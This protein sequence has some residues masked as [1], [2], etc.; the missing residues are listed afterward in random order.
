[1]VLIGLFVPSNQI[2]LKVYRGDD[3]E[4]CF[5][6][7]ITPET[8]CQDVVACVSS[9][10]GSYLT[11]QWQ[12][13]EKALDPHENLHAILRGWDNFR[14]EVRFIVREPLPPAIPPYPSEERLNPYPHEPYPHPGEIT[15]YPASHPYDYESPHVHSPQ[16]NQHI[17]HISDVNG[18]ISEAGAYSDSEIPQRWN[19]GGDRSVYDRWAVPVTLHSGASSDTLTPEENHGQR[20]HQRNGDGEIVPSPV[21]GL[22]GG[23]DLTLSELQD[24]AARQQQ[25]IEHQQQVLVAKEQRLKYLKQQDQRQQHIIAEGDRLK[26]LR[27]RVESQEMKLKKL[28]ALRGEVDKHRNTNGSLNTELESVKALFTEKEKELVMAVAKVEDLTRQLEAIRQERASAKNG[29]QNPAAIELEKLRK[30]LMVRNK[31]NDQQN[32]KLNKHRE[33][34]NQRKEEISK[35]DNR[36][37]ELQERLKKKRAHQAEQRKNL[38]NNKKLDANHNPR[39]SNVAQ[40][41]PYIQYRKSPDAIQS[42]ADLK[43]NFAKQDPKYQTLPP[44]TKLISPTKNQTDNENINS[45]HNKQEPKPP[46]RPPRLDSGNQKGQVTSSQVSESIIKAAQRYQPPV[47]SST[48]HPVKPPPPPR[49]ATTGLTYFTPRPYGSTYSSSVL[50]NRAQSQGLANGPTINVQEEIRQGGSGQ[51][52]PASSEGSQNGKNNDNTKDSRNTSHSNGAPPPRRLPPPLPPSSNTKDIPSEPKH[53]EDQVDS[54]RSLRKPPEQVVDSNVKS[55]NV[56][57]GNVNSAKSVE[58]NGA[59]NPS[60]TINFASKN[61]I[62][63]TYMGRLR[64]EALQKYQK[65]MDML[66][67]NLAR[68]DEADKKQESSENDINRAQNGQKPPE[69][70]PN[71]S[72]DHVHTFNPTGHQ[73]PDLTSDKISHNRP[74]KKIHRRPSDSSDS[75]EMVRLLHKHVD[76]HDKN[77][78][79]NNT[80][81]TSFIGGVPE[82]VPVDNMGNLMDDL[83]K[84]DKNDQELSSPEVVNMEVVPKK[85]T[86][87]RSRHSK[88]SGNRVSFDPLA[89]LLDA[90]LEGEVEMVKRCASQVANVSE[91]NDEGITALHN[92]ICAGHYDIVTFLVE[93]G[94]DVN[95]PDSD[96][97]TPLHCAASCNNIQM[98]IFLVEHG[99][100]IFATTISDHE[101]AAEKCEEDEDGFDGCSEYLYSIQEKLGILNGGVVYAVFDYEAKNKDEL[102]F[103]VNDEITVLR[104][105]DDVEKEWWWSRMGDKEGYIPR[106]LLGLYP[107][108]L[109]KDK[110][111]ES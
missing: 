27:D 53:A 54:S 86:N 107:R 74:A 14:E 81:A 47:S 110:G 34:L 18:Y 45:L 71:I 25:Q 106:N 11:Q 44:N 32:S 58:N 50:S 87:L 62:A 64:P 46:E 69:P 66:Y 40:V 35:M 91:P 31:L 59:N 63:N 108:V 7:P 98:V 89:L 20:A 52:S 2:I 33:M 67:K 109:Q 1:M 103:S 55:T 73:Y 37:H 97:W 101:T 68:G 30:E 3:L 85:K 83:D 60:K 82:D 61:Q 36:I 100:C 24:M 43:S 78:I 19:L 84:D 93:F 15:Q 5:E 77:H 38:D 95:S 21:N 29:T 39:P 111:E 48:G 42:E 88:S 79:L 26:K 56:N 16:N 6:V 28:R 49:S 92:A 23:V 105:G 75:E 96:G 90:S 9:E 12:G 10:E 4:K 72:H 51:S 99:A 65:N 17:V 102:S 57:G 41:E 70:Q 13:Q 104:K 80:Q 8:I 94:C 76:R 22:P